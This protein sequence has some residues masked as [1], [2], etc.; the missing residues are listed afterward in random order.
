MKKCPYCGAEYPDDATVCAIDQTPF[1]EETPRSS[2]NPRQFLQS[3]LGLAITTG[4]AIL[5]INTGIYFAVGRVNLEIFKALHPDNGV[6]RSIR[7]III[8]SKPIR[9]LLM[10]GFVAFTFTTCWM[11]CRKKPQAIVVAIITLAVTALLLYS[12]TLFVFA[13]PAFLI[14]LTTNSSAGYFIGSAMQLAA[15]AWLLGWFGR[16]KAQHEIPPD[17]TTADV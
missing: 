8:L 12:G 3:P 13:V 16:P 1:E 14:G 11:R 7:E 5:L 17:Q 10:V 15:G 6:P 4:L 2:E 9:W